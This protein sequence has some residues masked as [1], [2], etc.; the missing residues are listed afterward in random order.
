M[1]NPRQEKF[2]EEYLSNGGNAAEAYIAAG[3]N[4]KDGDIAK[5]AACRLMKK[6]GVKARLKEL[7]NRIPEERIASVSECQ[8]KLSEIMRDVTVKAIARIKA[9]EILMRSQGA[10]E[11]Q[12]NVS[13]D[14]PIIISGSDKI[15]D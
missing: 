5:S 15:E 4:V 11:T 9:A 14:V 2:C 10:F 13:A 8:E 7:M 12:I 1:L 6:P 3:F